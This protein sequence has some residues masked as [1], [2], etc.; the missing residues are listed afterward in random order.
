MQNTTHRVKLI[1]YVS[2][3]CRLRQVL[4]VVARVAVASGT[5]IGVRARVTN[6]S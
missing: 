2:V 1:Y 6:I 4:T 5:Q 3:L